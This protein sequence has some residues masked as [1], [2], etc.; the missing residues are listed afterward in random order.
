MLGQSD[1]TPNYVSLGRLVSKAEDFSPQPI[2]K[3][4]QQKKPCTNFTTPD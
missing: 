2:T 1:F 4:Q 3:Q